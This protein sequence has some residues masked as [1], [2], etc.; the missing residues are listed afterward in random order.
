M[1]FVKPVAGRNVRDPASTLHLPEHGKAVADE[2]YWHRRWKSGDIEW[3]TEAAIAAGVKAAASELAAA[4]KAEHHN[5]S[6]GSPAPK[7]SAA[8]AAEKDKAAK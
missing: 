3:T 4:A 2:S 5:E 1:L 7:H 6:H 8:H